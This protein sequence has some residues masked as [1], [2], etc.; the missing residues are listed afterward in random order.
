[1]VGG[2][3]EETDLTGFVT[4][5]E[6]HWVGKSCVNQAARRRREV[7]GER[8]RLGSGLIEFENMRH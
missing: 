4:E 1:M 5:Q 8:E 6:G 7:E 2:T 3:T